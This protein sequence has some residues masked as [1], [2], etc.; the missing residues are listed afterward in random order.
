[1]STNL[2]TIDV[3]VPVEVAYDQWTMLQMFPVFMDDVD[4][5]TKIGKGRHRWVTKIAGVEREFESEVVD[6]TPAQRI[7]WSSVDGLQHEGE[8]T[9]EPV[10]DERTTITVCLDLEPNTATE[11]LAD[12]LGV[13]RRRL[14]TSLEEFKQNVEARPTG[15]H[16]NASYDPYA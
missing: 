8:V 12:K 2:A 7:A 1:M 14:Q 6:Q 4:A 16:L 10:D 15:V 5:V 9:F 3:D 11:H 13:V